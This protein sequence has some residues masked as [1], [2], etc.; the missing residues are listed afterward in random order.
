MKFSHVYTLLKTEGHTPAKAAEILLAARRGDKQAR[1]WIVI[2][3][4]NRNQ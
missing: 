3:F 4:R 2:F 1:R